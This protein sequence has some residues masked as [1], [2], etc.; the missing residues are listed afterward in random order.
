MNAKV[1]ELYLKYREMGSHA[2]SALR[3]AKIDVKRK[4]IVW[5]DGHDRTTGHPRASFKRNGFDITIKV[6]DEECPDLSFVGEFTDKFEPGAIKRNKPGRNEFKYFVPGNS[7]E[8]HRSSL[9]KMGFSKGESGRMAAEYVHRDMK[10]LEDGI[11]QVYVTVTASKAG[12]ELGSDSLGGI[13]VSDKEGLGEMIEAHG[14]IDNAIE[15]AKVERVRIC[16]E[17]CPAK[18]EE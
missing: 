1:R 3:S 14:M 9:N 10:M 6:G 16:A 2:A 12:V 13:D 15:A 4:P 7:F 8:D 18:G 5:T 17:L 11:R